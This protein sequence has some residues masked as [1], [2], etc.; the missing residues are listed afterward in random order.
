MEMGLAAPVTRGYFCLSALRA[1]LTRLHREPSVSIRKKN[2]LWNSGYRY[3]CNIDIGYW[4]RVW[5]LF[6]FSS[7]CLRGQ[8]IQLL[9]WRVKFKLRYYFFPV[10]FL[11]A[12]LN[13][14]RSFLHAVHVFYFIFCLGRLTLASISLGTYPPT[15]IVFQPA[16][17]FSIFHIEAQLSLKNA[18]LPPVFFLDFNSPWYDLLVSQSH[19]LEKKILLISGHRP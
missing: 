7:D 6:L 8:T 3:V 1:S 2:I 15:T 16:R 13:Y 17:L 19:Y 11:C 14:D 9:C 18:W 12:R 5:P 10:S 4:W